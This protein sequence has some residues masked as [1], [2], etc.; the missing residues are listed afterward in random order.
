M[1]MMLLKHNIQM[2][3]KKKYCIQTALNW[4]C[5]EDF[6]NSKDSMEGYFIS[7]VEAPWY[8]LSII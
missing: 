7:T 5:M 3:Y 8:Q 1:I 4:T 2:P 6:G